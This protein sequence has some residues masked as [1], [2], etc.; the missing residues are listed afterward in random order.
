VTI[1][2]SSVEPV[3]SSGR[4]ADALKFDDDLFDELP[5]SSQ[6]ILPVIAN[7]LSP[8]AQGAQ[9]ISIVV[10]GAESSGLSVPASA[11]KEARINR[12]PY[13]AE[14]R[15]PGKGRVEIKTKDGSRKRIRGGVAL[16]A[17][18][19]RFDARNPF[20]EEKPDVGRRAFEAYLSG[21]LSSNSASFF[22]S[23]ER[24][25]NDES[26]IVNARTPAGPVIENIPT[27]ERR[28]RWLGRLEYYLNNNHKFDARYDFNNEVERNRGVGGLNLRSQAIGAAERRHRFQISESAILSS[29]F[30]NNLSL[31]L[32]RQAE[33]RGA[34]A[35]S[36]AIVVNGAF[37]DGPSQTFWESRETALRFQDAATYPRGRHTLRFGAE[38]RPRWIEASEGSSISLPL[39]AHL[40]SASTRVR[41]P[42][43]SRNTKRPDSSRMR[44]DYAQTSTSRW[45]FAT[46]GNQTLATA[47]ILLP[48]WP[49]LMPLEIRRLFCV[50]GRES[51][52][53][54]CLKARPGGR[55]SLMARGFGN[56]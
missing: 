37:T 21:P 23:G 2:G 10:D 55:R 32:E 5:I 7:F 18:D 17:R 44:R 9:G 19:S 28:S 4:N 36:P 16:F 24:L 53:T 51:F 39:Q 41:W 47:T 45:A 31:I 14:F 35:T 46:I 8:A 22:L 12:N 49:S 26:A 3:V 13:A 6:N 34:P 38:A 42:H 52:M 27:P 11:I 29:N 20:A 30:I 50:A 48:A 43:P 1:S 25:I 15:R 54:I 33:R 40:C 56:W